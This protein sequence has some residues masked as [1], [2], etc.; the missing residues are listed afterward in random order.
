MNFLSKRPCHFSEWDGSQM[1]GLVAVCPW[2][3]SSARHTRQRC[4]PFCF[5]LFGGICFVGKICFVQL[6]S[7]SVSGVS[8]ASGQNEGVLNQ[9]TRN[10]KKDLRLPR[11]LAPSAKRIVSARNLGVPMSKFSHITCRQVEKP[12]ST[13]SHSPRIFSSSPNLGTQE[14]TKAQGT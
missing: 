3:W 11:S 8:N 10:L 1:S 5:L 12:A 9:T 13:R 6:D 2:L 14:G 7:G 4:W